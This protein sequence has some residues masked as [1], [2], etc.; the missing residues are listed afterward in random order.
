MQIL[1]ISNIVK[2]M[3]AAKLLLLS[4]VKF[5]LQEIMSFQQMLA[6]MLIYYSYL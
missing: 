5:Y 1:E 4:K 3:S 6:E 2:A